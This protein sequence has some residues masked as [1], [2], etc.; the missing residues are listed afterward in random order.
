MRIVVVEDDPALQAFIAKAL[1]A[2]GHM[3]TCVGDGEAAVHQIVPAHHD[4][5]LLDLGLPKRDGTEVLQILRER[6][7]TIP[8]LVLT[9]RDGLEDRLRCFALGADDFLR[10][11]FSLQELMARCQAL[12]RRTSSTAAA[13]LALGALRLD[14]MAHTAGFR[15]SKVDLT[16][17]EFALL[18]YLMLQGG[19][20]V[21]RK[22]LLDEVW[23]LAPAAGTNVVDVYVNYLR[24]KLDEVGGKSASALIETVRGQG[25]RVA[26][27]HAEEPAAMPAER[28]AGPWLDDPD[29]REG[30]A[31]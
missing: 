18:E 17:K 1:Q 23:R 21:S 28:S 3:V 29:K 15:G 26:L 22:E 9:G 7:E 31:A 6:D 20:A 12:H 10:K 14:R 4:L 5:M 13:V 24:R 8:V 27:Q 25:Y 11:P 30:A 2:G 19:R 16:G